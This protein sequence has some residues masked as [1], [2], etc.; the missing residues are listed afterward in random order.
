M[1]ILLLGNIITVILAFDLA[2]LLRYA[3]IVDVHWNQH[4]AFIFVL[5]STLLIQY[6]CNCFNR[7]MY[8]ERLKLLF[9]IIKVW[10]AAIVF[11]LIVGFL[12][13]YYFLI[14]SRGFLIVYF[15]LLLHFMAL[16][17]LVLIPRLLAIYY[18]RPARK[19]RCGFI[20]PE[21]HKRSYEEFAKEHPYLGLTFVSAH[22][23][24]TTF[25]EAH[26]YFLYSETELFS[27]L[28][29]QIRS[30]LRRLKPLHVCSNLFDELNLKWEWARVDDIPM[31]TFQ[32]QD[33]KSVQELA[34]RVI[35]IVGAAVLMII[36]S[37]LF[38][39]ITLAVKLDSPG[40][41]I[42]KQ[43]RCGRDGKQF[44]FYKFR[45][46]VSN[47]E[48]DSVRELEFK[49]YLEE[50]TSKG[51]ILDSKDI[52]TVGSVLRKASIDE[53][54]QL[55]NVLRGDMSLVG[56]RPPIPYEVKYYKDW[57]MDRLSVKQGL[58]GLW[59]IYGRGEMP[60]DKSIFLDMIYVI[61][62]SLIVDINLILQTI[63]AVILGKGAY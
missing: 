3:S 15:F 42:Y 24:N 2:L 23:E 29:K 36:L 10:L 6:F 60:S 35:D 34:K 48:S 7:Y 28:Y 40:P 30:S 56:P 21:K 38:L 62:R 45:S 51:K 53:L 27:E 8:V 37:P 41:I 20:G 19:I 12:T 11:Y 63:P 4:T 47:R 49:K 1:L 14:D 18:K 52:T 16:F 9:N 17:H 61:N 13:R 57:H 25:E 44:I 59:Q 43:K 50:E 55:W 32:Q 58:T 54:P 46:M 33:N 22:E 31:Y 5:S 26:E 39:I